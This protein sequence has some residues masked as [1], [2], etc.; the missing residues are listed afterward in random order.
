MSEPLSDFINGIEDD[1]AD[2]DARKILVFAP[3]LKEPFAD[4]QGDRCI[5]GAEGERL[6]DGWCIE[7]RSRNHCVEPICS[8]L[9]S[10]RVIGIAATPPA[11]SKGDA[12]AESPELN[13]RKRLRNVFRSCGI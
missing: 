1:L 13:L 3:V 11:A 7:V 12:A 5:A 4:T 8:G 9:G 10:G 2:A 6:D